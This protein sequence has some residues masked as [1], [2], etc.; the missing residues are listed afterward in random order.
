[1]FACFR[2]NIGGKADFFL[3]F[4]SLL[5]FFLDY[6]IRVTSLLCVLMYSGLHEMDTEPLKTAALYGKRLQGAELFKTS[7][8]LLKIFTRL[9]INGKIINNQIRT[10]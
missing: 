4:L 2:K 1:M 7:C 10:I 3:H 5:D 6:Y 9:H 8:G